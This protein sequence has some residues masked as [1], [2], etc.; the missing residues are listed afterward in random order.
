MMTGAADSTETAQLALHDDIEQALSEQL[1]AE[2]EL[3]EQHLFLWPNS[4]LKKPPFL[5]QQELAAQQ[6]LAEQELAE[7][8]E[9]TTAEQLLLHEPAEQETTTPLHEAEQLL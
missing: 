8:L 9:T 1:E 2:Q 7:Q 4:F 5:L 3:A 6:E